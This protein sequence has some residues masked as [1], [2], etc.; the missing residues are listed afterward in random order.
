MT[1]ITS[2]KELK[3]W[4]KEPTPERPIVLEWFVEWFFEQVLVEKRYSLALRAYCTL[5]QYDMICRKVS[6]F[7]GKVA[8]DRYLRRWFKYY[9]SPKAKEEWGMFK[10][11]LIKEGFTGGE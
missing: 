5:I 4:N 3:D 9:A 10:L 7:R 1:K 6:V 11:Y 2:L 8:V